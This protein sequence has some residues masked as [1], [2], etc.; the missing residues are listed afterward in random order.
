MVLPSAAQSARTK[1]YS[2]NRA[3]AQ[4]IKPDVSE[5]EK[6]DDVIRVDTELVII[7]FRVTDKKGRSVSDIT[8]NE[9]RIFEGDEEREIEHFGGLEQPFTVA[10]LLDMSYSSVFKL[11]DIQD[12]ARKFIA[13]L[14][15]EDRVMV[16]S[17]D[18]KPL[19]LCEA[20]NNR[21]AL[22]IAID[23]A[24]IGSGTGLY[25][26][27]DLVLNEKMANI[28]G[29]KAVVLLS[30]GVDT[31]S[32]IET[33]NSVRNDVLESDLLIYPIRYNTYDDVLKNRRTT[34]PIQYDDNDKP[35]TVEPPLAKGERAEDYAAA[36]E[37]LNGMA[38]DTGGRVYNVSSTTNLDRAFADI[39]KELR[40]F[41]SLG[42]YPSDGHGDATSFD[43]R[44]RVYRPGLNIRS[45]ER[46]KT[47]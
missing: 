18:E 25:R 45:R 10:L 21:K 40:N 34:A 46:I 27:L 2:E 19:V 44:I 23:G 11:D 7:P 41:Y 43:I 13:Q 26:T 9:V 35:Y 8:K 33:A 37:F 31:S 29:R 32:V 17:F 39:A 22:N 1:K 4:R 47:H 14:G 12:A 16:I 30:D 20:T 5:G 36:T 3:T 38:S 15:P 24:R 42:Y 28:E 6:N